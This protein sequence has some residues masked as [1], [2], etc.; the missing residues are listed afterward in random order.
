MELES[1]DPVGNTQFI[2][3]PKNITKTT[4]QKKTMISSLM[5][6]IPDLS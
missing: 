1:L 3:K 5:R 4:S 6:L 2:G